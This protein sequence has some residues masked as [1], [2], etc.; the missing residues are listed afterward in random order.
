MDANQEEG[1][2]AGRPART[3]A[4]RPGSRERVPADASRRIGPIV[5]RAQA[6]PAVWR[7]FARLL[8]IPL[9]YKVLLANAALVLAVAVVAPMLTV[10]LVRLWSSLTTGEVVALIA[11][12]SVSV[13]VLLNA[14]ILRIALAPLRR[15]ERTAARVQ[16]GELG[17]RA[18]LSALADRDLD[19]LV[20]TFNG[21]L[22]STAAYRQRL[23]E[24]AVRALDA[25]EEERKRVSRELHDGIAQSLA[26][27]RIR[28]RLA[29]AARD[30]AERRSLLDEVSAA[31]GAATEEVR[32]I[33]RG[34][35]P[36][37]LDMLGLAPAIESYARGIAETTGL[38][39]DIDL[40][41]VGGLLSPEAELALYRVL[42]EA[43]SNVVR[44][45]GAANV[46]V[47]LRKRAGF[48]EAIVEDDGRGFSVDEALRDERG[49]LGL[50]GMKERASYVG[51]TVAIHSEPGTGTRVRAT[52]PIL[53]GASDG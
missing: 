35:R 23:R 36:P 12:A 52:I 15:L 8:R 20:V 45:A 18:P 6:L 51:G 5:P 46:R 14:L 26:A 24:I 21:M 37:A 44:H 30:D 42:Q 4:R 2:R 34:L 49:G 33:A 27:L 29:R 38:N 10:R 40:D 19:R 9:F 3:E 17:A 39:V 22:D 7:P 16:A 48:V 13:S 11:L 28:L 43:L 47:R 50:F 1:V 31:I 25:A 53:E 41:A 32:S